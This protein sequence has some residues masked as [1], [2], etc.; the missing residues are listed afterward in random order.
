MAVDNAAKQH[1]KGRCLCGAV[2]FDVVL[3]SSNV[4][5]CHCGMCR[6]QA[7]APMMFID[8]VGT[9]S[10]KGQDNITDYQSSEWGVRG[11]CKTCGSQLYWRYIGLDNYS[12]CAGVLDNVSDMVLEREIYI[13]DQPAFYKFTPGARRLTSEEAIAEYTALNPEIT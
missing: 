11:F 4:G 6:R 13:D 9:P 8:A 3:A 1:V 5:V 7:S 12:M 10:F 2:T